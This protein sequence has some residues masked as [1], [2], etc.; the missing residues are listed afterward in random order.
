LPGPEFTI[1]K[2]EVEPVYTEGVVVG[3]GQR[4]G[5]I[6]LVEPQAK[7]IGIAEAEFLTLQRGQSGWVP[8]H[9]AGV[10]SDGIEGASHRDRSCS[11]GRLPGGGGVG[12]AGK[13][14]Q[15]ERE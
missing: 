3:D 4:I 7:A 6:G 12:A 15:R 5:E 2:A 1:V 14:G 13:Q 9:G 8:M 10:G 11:Q